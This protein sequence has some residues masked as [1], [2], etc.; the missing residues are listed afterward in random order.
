M[1]LTVIGF[2]AVLAAFSAIL[3]LLNSL[4]IRVSQIQPADDS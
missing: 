4:P 3:V 2:I 1:R